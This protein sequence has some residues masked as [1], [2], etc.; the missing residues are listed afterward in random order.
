MSPAWANFGSDANYAAFR[1]RNA[2]ATRA[3]ALRR[4]GWR[5]RCASC[6]KDPADCNA[7]PLICNGKPHWCY[8][9]TW[10]GAEEKIPFCNDCFPREWKSQ[11][12]KHQIPKR[13]HD[14]RRG[15]AL[16][17]CG[18]LASRVEM[19]RPDTPGKPKLNKRSNCRVCCA[20]FY[21]NLARAFN[22]TYDKM[23]NGELVAVPTDEEFRREGNGPSIRRQQRP[24]GLVLGT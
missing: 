18:R 21:R 14:Q 16:T 9:I 3:S 23:R 15:T 13:R 10:V 1:E 7:M 4:H 8:L 5:R 17:L 12:W 22:R 19:S 20:V 6:G 24:G 11:G 2:A